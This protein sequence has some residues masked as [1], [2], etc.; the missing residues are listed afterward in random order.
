[1]L[2]GESEDVEV[3][4]KMLDESLEIDPSKGKGSEYIDAMHGI[5]NSEPK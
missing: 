1:M 3:F 2:S 4:L 5:G